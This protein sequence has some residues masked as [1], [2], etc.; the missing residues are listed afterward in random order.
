MATKEDKF[1][2]FGPITGSKD[3]YI[4]VEVTGINEDGD[5]Y[6]TEITQDT[7]REWAISSDQ[8]K[9]LLDSDRLVPEAKVN[10]SHPL[11][12]LLTVVE[13]SRRNDAATDR[14]DN[15]MEDAQDAVWRTVLAELGI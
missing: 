6:F 12:N 3:S 11:W 8:V 13:A 4:D 10:P 15:L 7:P 1:R 9:D 14:G 5:V 2:V